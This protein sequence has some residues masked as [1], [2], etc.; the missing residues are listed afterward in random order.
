LK[1]TKLLFSIAVAYAVLLL[2]TTGLFASRTT[3]ALPL[4]G[5]PLILITLLIVRDLAQRSTDTPTEQPSTSETV[6]KMD[7]VHFLSNQIR[8]AADASDSYF[9][10]IVRV[11]LKELLITKITVETGMEPDEVRRTL[12]FSRTGLELVGDPTLYRILYGPVPTS[13]QKR[14][15]VVRNAVELIGDWKG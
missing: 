1:T 6:L 10:D 13:K 8:G 15:E 9:D 2:L 3:S 5:I 7:P 11:R 12:S 4:T 14:I